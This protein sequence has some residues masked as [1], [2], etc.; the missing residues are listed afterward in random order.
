MLFRSVMSYCTAAG[1]RVDQVVQEV[2][3]AGSLAG[4]SGLDKIF[5][6]VLRKQ[7]SMVVV[8]TPDRI[9]R[10]AGSEIL[11]R[12]LAWH[13]VEYHVIQ[14]GLYSEEYREELKADL[15]DL[16]YESRKLIGD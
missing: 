4:R 15:T 3:K 9:A 16:I 14:K 13:G 5:E 12:F 11:E 8:E 1:I 7:L 10:F 6:A 2:G